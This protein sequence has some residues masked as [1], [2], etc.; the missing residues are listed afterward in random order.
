MSPAQTSNTAN[1][2]INSQARSTE[3]LVVDIVNG[4]NVVRVVGH[5]S[6]LG[7][8]SVLAGLLSSISRFVVETK[9]ERKVAMDYN[10]WV[11]LA[12]SSQL[13]HHE[14]RP[15]SSLDDWAKDRSNNAPQSASSPV[16]NSSPTLDI[17]INEFTTLGDLGGMLSFSCVASVGANALMDLSDIPA[18][19]TAA[20]SSP[21]QSFYAPFQHNGFFVPSPY[22]TMAYGTTPW[23]SQNPLPLSNYSSLNGATTSSAS[24]SSS[25]QQSTQQQQ[26]Q[27]PSKQPSQQ[28]QS[29]SQPMIIECVTAIFSDLKS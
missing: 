18:S 27:Q 14:Q 4:A 17:N 29:T 19:S 9:K 5:S 13:A 20:P 6:S 16:S 28:H 3:A 26:Q 21:Q 24:S 15:A 7:A 10:Q 12:E 25:T 11:Q 1:N 8:Q 22:T 23:S 2:A